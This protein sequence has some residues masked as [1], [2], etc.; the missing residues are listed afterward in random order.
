MEIA[1]SGRFSGEMRPRKVRIA[2]HLVERVNAFSEAMVNSGQPVRACE[3]FAL[4]IRYRDQGIVVPPR[5]DLRQVLQVEPTVQRGHG[6]RRQIFEE[7][8][9]DEIDME[10]QKIEFVR[11]K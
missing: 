8:K 5:I 11:R 9:M 7:R 4:I 3:W 6:S 10:M 1:R 2:G